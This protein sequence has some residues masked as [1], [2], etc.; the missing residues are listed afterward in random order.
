MMSETHAVQL[1]IY[2]FGSGASFEGQLVGAL[3]RLEA[4]GALKIVDL[5]FVG[6]DPS[7]GERFAVDMPSGG[8]AGIV[9]PLLGFRLD[10]AERRRLTR[11]ALA[12][13]GER[14][15]L[16]ERLTALLAPGEAAAAMLIDHEWAR[17]LA[18]AVDRMGG[19][20]VTNAFVERTSL[21]TLAAEVLAAA[22]QGSG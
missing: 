22:R 8:A 12:R 16:I 18:D 7:T 4:G 17:V 1:L 2:R 13:G 11:R 10:P 9:A 5:L 3:E 15:E 21:A 20:Q 19:S 6:S 14:A